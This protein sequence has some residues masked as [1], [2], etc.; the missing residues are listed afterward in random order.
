ML[1]YVFS[2]FKST[3]SDY[4]K[5]IKKRAQQFYY[6]LPTNY[7]HAIGL[8]AG[9]NLAAPYQRESWFWKIWLTR[10]PAAKDVQAQALLSTAIRKARHFAYNV[11][12]RELR[13][14]VMECDSQNLKRGEGKLDIFDTA[15]FVQCLTGLRINEVFRD[16]VEIT[17]DPSN[18]RFFKQTGTS[19]QAEAAAREFHSAAPVDKWTQIKP[20]TFDVEYAVLKNRLTLVRKLAKELYE[21][22]AKGHTYEQATAKQITA[23]F[24]PRVNRRMRVRFPTLYAHALKFNMPFGSHLARAIYANVAWEEWGSTLPFTSKPA[25][26]ADNL[27]HNATNISTSTRYSN[28][29]V[30]MWLRTKGLMPD[31]KVTLDNFQGAMKSQSENMRTVMRTVG[32]L[33]SNSKKW[34]PAMRGTKPVTVVLVNA[35]GQELR[36]TRIKHQRVSMKFRLLKGSE[37]AWSLSSVE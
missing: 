20:I 33:A 8:P 37:N 29:N 18:V 23:A 7:A 10:T 27:L 6:E 17:P 1:Y 5:I 14:Y 34:D 35:A 28:I 24:D 12:Y 16:W 26:I 13:K 22:S 21:N 36:L 3:A 19:K 32:E 15:I 2:P 25:F 31:V 4:F 30:R 11:D 9:V